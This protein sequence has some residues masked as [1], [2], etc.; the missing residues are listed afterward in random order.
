MKI[1]I[2]GGTGKEGRGLALR[3]GRAGVEVLIGSRDPDRA[4]QAAADLNA[5][6]ERKTASGFSNR[7]AAEK[8]EVIVSTLPHSGHTEILSAI[9]TALE[10]KLLL[11]ATVVWPPGPLDRRSAAEEVQDLVFGKARV[12]AAFQTVS[13]AELADLDRPVEDHVLVC[14]DDSEARRRA[15]ELIGRAGMQAVNAGPLRQARTVEA[16]T[17]LLLQI[18]KNYKIKASGIRI[19]GLP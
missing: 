14:G 5:R 18:N 15:I 11:V 19:T 10:G 6:L 2:L 16:I 1:A 8:A 4:G 3:W 13:A 7:Q 12:V 9:T 17:G